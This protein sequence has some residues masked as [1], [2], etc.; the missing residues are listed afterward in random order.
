ML[1]NES[2]LVVVRYIPFEAGLACHSLVEAENR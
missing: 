2:D 1:F